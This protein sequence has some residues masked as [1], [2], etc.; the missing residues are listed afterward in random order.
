MVYYSI[1][2]LGV[3]YI[4]HIPNCMH[5]TPACLSLNYKASS[6]LSGVSVKDATEKEF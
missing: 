3:Q 2:A 6:G 4:S 5:T 1:A